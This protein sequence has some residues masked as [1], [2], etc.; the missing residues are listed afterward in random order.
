MVAHCSLQSMFGDP[1]TPLP[2]GVVGVSDALRVDTY[3]RQTVPHAVGLD[4]VLGSAGGFLQ[5]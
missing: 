2:E 3:S 4:T 5:H 1:Q